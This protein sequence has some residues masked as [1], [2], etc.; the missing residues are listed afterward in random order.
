MKFSEKRRHS[1]LFCKHGEMTEG[2]DIK[3]IK[4]ERR[5]AVADNMYHICPQ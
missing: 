4:M 2:C 5:N 1:F 3:T